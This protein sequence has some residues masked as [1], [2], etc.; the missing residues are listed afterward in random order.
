MHCHMKFLPLLTLCNFVIECRHSGTNA[1][2]QLSG[3]ISNVGK[4]C[5]AA[6]S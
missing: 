6:G 3:N 1:V 4:L 5:M 2:S